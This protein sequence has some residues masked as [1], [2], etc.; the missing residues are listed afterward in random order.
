MP[1]TGSAPA[2]AL[3]IPGLAD[4]RFGGLD[5]VEIA[6][7]QYPAALL[8]VLPVTVA[9]DLGLFKVL[10]GSAQFAVRRFLGLA[11]F[12]LLLLTLFV[13]LVFGAL[14]VL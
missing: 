4:P 13:L 7:S 8:Q 14:D 5:T 9:L 3:C 1:T 12:R 2:A 6:L 10:L 11:L